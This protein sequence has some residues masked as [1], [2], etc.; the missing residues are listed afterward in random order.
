MF[1]FTLFVVG[2][3]KNKALGQLCDDFSK[4][5]ARQGS[6][7]TIEFK[8]G[9]LDSESQ[10]LRLAIEAK[11]DHEIFI[12][13]EEGCAYSSVK[14]A[15]KLQLN[16]GKPLLFII[17]GAYGMDPALK[18][19]GH[20]LLALSPLTFTHEMARYLL[21]EQLYRAVSIVQGGKYHH[22]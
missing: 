11:R 19:M 12:L 13:A 10:R 3:L 9:S 1:R 15:E 20:H 5:L 6:L 8:D 18:Q 17:G 4:R 21:L 14:F 16:R 22:E 7:Q 2:R